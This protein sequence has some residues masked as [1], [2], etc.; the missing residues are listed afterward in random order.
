MVG[1]KGLCDDSRISGRDAPPQP[2]CEESYKEIHGAWSV[3]DDWGRSGNAIRGDS[4]VKRDDGM[5]GGCLSFRAIIQ[6][7]AARLLAR[8]GASIRIGP[9]SGPFWRDNRFRSAMKTI[10]DMLEHARP[11]NHRRHA[12]RTSRAARFLFGCVTKSSPRS[13]FRSMRQGHV[14]TFLGLL[15]GWH[16]IIGH[17]AKEI[18]DRY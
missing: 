2:H 9:K 13:A 14:L 15:W 12:T 4:E 7:N 17:H 6:A 3:A 11:P 8:G 1:S 18:S 5:N 10:K 16:T